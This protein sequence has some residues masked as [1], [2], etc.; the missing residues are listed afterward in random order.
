[1]GGVKGEKKIRRVSIKHLIIINNNTN[2]NR[3][4]KEKG[5]RERTTEG[6][7]GEETKRKRLMIVVRLEKQKEWVKIHIKRI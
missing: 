2:I 7:F 4:K 6:N 3:S 1:M 5:E